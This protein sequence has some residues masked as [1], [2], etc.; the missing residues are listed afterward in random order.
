MARYR[1]VVPG[2][3]A[4]STSSVCQEACLLLICLL[5]S[6]GSSVYSAVCPW[7]LMAWTIFLIVHSLLARSFK[8]RALF[9]CGFSPFSPFFA[10]SIILLPLLPCHSAIPAVV[11]FDP[12]LLGLLGQLLILLLM[13]QYGHWFLYSCYF[14]LFLTHYT[15]CELF[16]PIS[17]FLSILG[18]F[19]FLGYH[20]PIF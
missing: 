4:C 8:G 19:A 18:P 9:D 15:A 13:T 1:L 6:R 10:L 12:Y 7:P 16:C 5:W 3:C 14:G 11:S 2:P 20:R 17:F